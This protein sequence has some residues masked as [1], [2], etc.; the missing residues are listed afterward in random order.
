MNQ[1]P[2]SVVTDREALMAGLVSAALD[3]GREIWAVFQQDFEVQWKSDS[4]PVTAADHAAEAVIL[5]AL[6]ILAPGVP[7][8][9]E[10]ESAAGRTPEVGRRFFLVDPL[11]GTREFVRKGGDF[12]V[13]IALIEDGTPTLGVVYA[14]ARAAL[15]VGDVAR[16]VAWRSD[17][18]P[19]NT[20]SPSPPRP[21]KVRA[22]GET[23]TVVAS[24]SHDVPET[25]AYLDSMGWPTARVAVGSSLKFCLVAAAEA[26][27]YPR[28]SPT[29][30]WDTAAGHAVLAAAGGRAFAPDGGP[31]RYGKPRF[32]N[33]GFVA[34]GPF[35]PPA[36]GPFM[37]P[38]GR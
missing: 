38:P 20:G 33:P 29:S 28:P 27:L 22:P 13:N 19:E 8:V 15:Y 35:D 4:S 7:V 21:L 18:D 24:K 30:E 31:L 6:A 9:A 25:E 36:I 16:G 5:K 3:A 1:V 37:G 14:P 23:L 2:E 17:V 12:T 32:F 10:E 11:D 34:S 26:D